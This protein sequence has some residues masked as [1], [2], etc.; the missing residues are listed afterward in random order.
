MIFMS[1]MIPNTA[2]IGKL[3]SQNAIIPTL[4]ALR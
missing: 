4:V 2:N 3:V 1:Q